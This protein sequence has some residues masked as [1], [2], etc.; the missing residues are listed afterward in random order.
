MFSLRGNTSPGAFFAN[1]K[2]A[3]WDEEVVID[4]WRLGRNKLPLF[5]KS[6]CISSLFHYP[7]ACR[8]TIVWQQSSD[9]LIDIKRSF[10]VARTISEA[11]F[12][13]DYIYSHEAMSPIYSINS[14]APSS[15]IRLMWSS[16]VPLRIWAACMMRLLM[17]YQFY[18]PLKE[19]KVKCHG[20][21][22]LEYSKPYKWQYSN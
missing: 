1:R 9:W 4:Y 14:Y 7:S 3:H 22:E 2:D 20:V 5:S 19:W 10:D 6:N 11:L 21:S 18:L 15:V 12:F 16:N 13:R 8:R 17:A